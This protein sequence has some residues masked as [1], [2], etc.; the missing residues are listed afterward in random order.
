MRAAR[1]DRP[2]LPRE[3]CT[4]L[5]ALW[6][7][8][9]N[10]PPLKEVA[11][12]ESLL[13]QARTEGAQE[14]APE[15]W[16]EAQEALRTAKARLQDRDY[17]GAISSATEAAERSRAAGQAA[18]AGKAAAR[19]AVEADRAEVDAV[20]AELASLREQA[21]KAKV[22][23]AVLAEVEGAAA[24]VNE[25]MREAETRLQQGDLLAAQALAAEL[26]AR[27][28]PLTTAFRQAQVKWEAAHPRGGRRR[29]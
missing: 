4:L 8:A 22:P 18:I 29:R 24:A 20:L 21:T 7:G 23:D 2:A 11:A 9:C 5:A 26:K 25:G 28:A 1:N 3:A 14:F 12:A 6:L 27:A 17:R 16:K 13:E 10:H 19:Q 15:R